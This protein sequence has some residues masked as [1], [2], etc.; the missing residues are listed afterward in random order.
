[1][2]LFFNL[3]FLMGAVLFVAGFAALFLPPFGSQ[4]EVVPN[5]Q[6]GAGFAALGFVMVV[7]SILNFP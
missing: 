2:S 1:M 3:M 4:T 7:I 5:K 6:I